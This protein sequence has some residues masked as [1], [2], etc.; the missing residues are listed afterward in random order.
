M[1][2]KPKQPAAPDLFGNF[3]SGQAKME[4]RPEPDPRASAAPKTATPPHSRAIQECR[5]EGSD[6][7]IEKHTDSEGTFWRLFIQDGNKW[8]RL[9]LS[10]GDAQYI[11]DMVLYHA[12]QCSTGPLVT[13]TGPGISCPSCGRHRRTSIFHFHPRD[14]EMPE[15]DPSLFWGSAIVSNRPRF[16]RECCICHRVVEHGQ[17]YHASRSKPVTYAHTDCREAEERGRKTT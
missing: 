2:A 12:E 10:G 4:T 17:V 14:P 15:Y 8:R 11:P 9:W 7:R 5:V 13:R 6:Y 1:R 3:G 16:V